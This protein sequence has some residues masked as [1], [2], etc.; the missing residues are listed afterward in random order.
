MKFVIIPEQ[1]YSTLIR[2]SHLL[3]K[4]RPHCVSI[5]TYSESMLYDMVKV[6]MEDGTLRS[7]LIGNFLLQK[8]FALKSSWEAI[9]KGVLSI[10]TGGSHSKEKE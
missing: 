5:E 10:S 4:L 8:L 1:Y 2:E 3:G 7:C 6:Q 9:E